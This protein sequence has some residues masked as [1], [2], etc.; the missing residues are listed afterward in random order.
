M[1]FDS[2]HTP[3]SGGLAAKA[4]A[5]APSL[6]DQSPEGVG[7]TAALHQVKRRAMSGILPETLNESG[8][9]QLSKKKR[10]SRAAKTDDALQGVI[11]SF[12][13]DYFQ[14]VLPNRDG[15]GTCVVG[16]REEHASMARAVKFF[17]SHGLRFGKPT[18]GGRGYGNGLP[19]FHEDSTEAVGFIAS[20]S[21]TGGMPNVTIKGG[22]GLC[23]DLAPMLQAAFPGIRATR[24]DV[25]TDI[26]GS[27]DTFDELLEMS[28]T[29]CHARKMH[30]PEVLG[31]ETPEYGRTFYVGSRKESS[32]FLRVYEKGKAENL[33]AQK[34]GNEQTADPRWIRL[35]FQHQKI[36]GRKK[37]AF[38]AMTPGELVCV[39]D[40][41][42]FW[43]ASAA[44]V[45]GLTD[46]IGKAARHI[47]EFEP[48][49]RTL[50]TTAEWG[51]KQYGRVFCTIGMRELV[52]RNHD[53]DYSDAVI[54]ENDLALEASEV[55]RAYLL[56]SGKA[57]AIIDEFRLNICERPDQ[58]ADEASTRLQQERMRG[59]E[60]RAERRSNLADQVGSSSDDEDGVLNIH[61]SALTEKN[62]L[63][64]AQEERATEWA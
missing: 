59:L 12:E 10:K 20:G 18:S 28:R 45:I 19:F 11:D 53:G 41:P 7:D 29:F 48:T 62:R 42:R 38:A 44:K 17:E 56:D 23:A 2:T 39:R 64:K 32:V 24:I 21:T 60:L 6:R 37:A 30:A 40:W 26:I 58:R 3:K 9:D 33:K 4:S 25:C 34:A 47:A 35:E 61:V 14:G 22:H 43:I 8:S 50:H 54:D 16:G 46:A 1:P 36:E 31:T 27:D 5:S 63:R 52:R 57:V 51:I 49:V 15:A 13:F 55:F